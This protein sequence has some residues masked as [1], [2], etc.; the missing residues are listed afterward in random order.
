MSS[1]TRS[2]TD[3][4]AAGKAS[5]NGTSRKNGHRQRELRK[6]SDE[7]AELEQR[8][9]NLTGM[10]ATLDGERARLMMRVHML[11]SEQ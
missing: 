2:G 6:V 7:I 9:S 10:M 11:R 8:I 3:A 5:T 4:T 1:V